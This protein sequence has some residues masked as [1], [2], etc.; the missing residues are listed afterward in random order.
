MSG[1]H[2][3]VRGRR[4]A[5]RGVGGSADSSVEG[6][7]RGTGDLIPS[8]IP[9]QSTSINRLSPSPALSPCS[10]CHCQSPPPTHFLHHHPHELPP[11]PIQQQAQGAVA[12]HTGHTGDSGE[13]TLA[14]DSVSAEEHR[15]LCPYPFFIIWCAGEGA[16]L[17]T[18]P[19]RALSRPGRW[20]LPLLP[21]LHHHRG[22]D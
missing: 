3:A 7:D 4:I 13:A 18:L 11:A 10:E 19:G 1:L 6:C 16:R 8:S 12:L 20:D 2:R 5:T 21:L 14:L 15:Q 9:P 17:P 22:D